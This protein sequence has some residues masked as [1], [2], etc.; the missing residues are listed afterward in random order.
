VIDTGARPLGEL[1]RNAGVWHSRRPDRDLPPG[2]S[3]R[4]GD[5]LAGYLQEA[6][7]VARLEAIFRR[8]HF[9]DEHLAATLERATGRTLDEPQAAVGA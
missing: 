8:S 1:C 2:A 6:H 7:G 3:Y 4:V 5:A 9:R